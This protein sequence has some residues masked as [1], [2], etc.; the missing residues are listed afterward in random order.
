MKKKVL[1]ITTLCFLLIL[2]CTGC[3]NV[4]RYEFTGSIIAVNPQNRGKTFVVQNENKE[5]IAIKYINS[6]S[7]DIKNFDIA[8][9]GDNVYIEYYIDGDYN[10]ATKFQIL[11]SEEN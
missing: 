9:V 11:N 2:G 4:K 7:P 6:K 1:L 5:R 8:I 3:D 10:C